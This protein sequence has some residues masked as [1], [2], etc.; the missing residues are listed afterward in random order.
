[1]K[2]AVPTT[3]TN[4]LPATI[5]PLRRGS[6]RRITDLLPVVPTQ[7][8]TPTFYTPHQ[9]N[10]SITNLYQPSYRASG[11]VQLLPRTFLSVPSS[12]STNLLNQQAATWQYTPEQR[13]DAVR[14]YRE[15]KLRRRGNATAIRYQVRKQ[16]ADTRPRFRGRFS[17]PSTKHDDTEATEAVVPT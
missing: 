1:M 2:S 6:P 9:R 13:K 14:R 7:R 17:K 16:L 12:K 4:L 11:P 5:V 8:P 15:K 10:S 3:N